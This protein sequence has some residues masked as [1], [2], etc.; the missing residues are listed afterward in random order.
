VELGDT[1]NH[2]DFAVLVES[3]PRDDLLAWLCATGHEL[4]LPEAQRS[5]ALSPGDWWRVGHAP[6]LPVL[7][8]MTFRALHFQFCDPRGG[9][10]SGDADLTDSPLW[11]EWGAASGA[12]QGTGG[13]GAGVA[14]DEETLL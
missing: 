14:K 7:R 9:C 12:A 2:R 11:I 4:F 13:S 10:L 3:V 8:G 1:L 6:V 5:R